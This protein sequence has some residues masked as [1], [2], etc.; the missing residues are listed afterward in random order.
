[1]V[2]KKTQK[3]VAAL[4]AALEKMGWQAQDVRIRSGGDVLLGVGRDVVTIELRK[5]S[6]A[7]KD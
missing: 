5:I 7:K 2:S 3:D 4:V 1:M 6:K